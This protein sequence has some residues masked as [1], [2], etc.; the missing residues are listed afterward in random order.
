MQ[1]AG[2]TE[3]TFRM[4]R[5]IGSLVSNEES[6]RGEKQRRLARLDIRLS[7]MKRL[8]VSTSVHGVRRAAFANT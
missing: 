7:D 3:A 4:A 6:G 1:R 8:G 5:D 2:E